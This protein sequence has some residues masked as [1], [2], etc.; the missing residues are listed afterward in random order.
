MSSFYTSVVWRKLSNNLIYLESNTIEA[1]AGQVEQRLS[2]GRKLHLE[3]FHFIK[4]L[5]KG[6]FGK[7]MLAEK[8]GGTSDEVY[9]IKVIELLI[10]LI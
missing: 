5:G 10:R 7:V 3:D 8:K 4:V 6:S 1:V 9:A 2:T